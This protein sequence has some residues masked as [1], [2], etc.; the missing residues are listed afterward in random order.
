MFS[1]LA[2]LGLLMLVA[3]ATM[4]QGGGSTPHVTIGGSV[5]GGGNLANVG[6][7]STVLVD[8][9]GTVIGEDVYGGGAL[10]N[11]GTTS[12]DSTTVTILN[13][14]ING[15][16]YGGGLGDSIQNCY[17]GSINKA[18]LVYGKVYVNIGNNSGGPTINGSV[19]GC[20]NINGTPLDSVFVNIYK[21][22]H[23][24]SNSY[25][26]GIT[27]MAG[28]QASFN[29]SN[30]DDCFAIEAVYGGGNKASYK[31]S[32]ADRATT[33][34]VYGCT[35]NTIKVIYGGGNA[36][37]VGTSSKHANTRL[38]IEGGRFDQ[39]FGGGNGYSASG[40]H[41]PNNC[42]DPDYNPG[43]NITGTASTDIQGGLYRQIFGGSN[44]FGDVDVVALSIDKICDNL[45]ISEAFGGANEAELQANVETNLGCGDYEIGSFYGGSNKANIV[46]DVTLNVYGG[47]YTNVFG[48]SKGVAAAT[49]LTAVPANIDGNVTLNLFGGTMVNAFGGSDKNGNIT[50]GITVN[51]LD[52]E[53]TNCGLDVTNI[54]GA[55]NETAYSPTDPTITSPVVNVMH[56]AQ[57]AGVK[58]NVF[59]GGNLA[60]VTANPTVNIGYVSSMSSYITA[61]AA[62]L[63]TNYSV[64]ANSRA[65]VT[66]KVFGGGNEAGVTNTVVNINS[67][68]VK[69]G[70]YGGCNTSGTVGGNI[71][72]NL[73]NGQVGTDATNR[74]DVF[75]G[76]YGSNTY[77]SGDIVVNLNSTTIYGDLYGGSA[78]G[79]V[80]N[81]TA[82]PANT[83]TLTINGSALHG[84]IYGGGKGDVTNLG[85]GHNNVTAVNNGN[86]IVNYNTANTALT[87]LYGGANVNGNVKGDITVNV[88]ANVGATGTG[89]SVDVFGG[90]LGA[91]TDT[92]GNVTVNIGTETMAAA[93]IPVIYGDIYGGSALG[94]VNN[95]A[96]DITKVDFLNGTLHGNIYGG[97]L[98]DANN[99]AKVNGEVIVNI[100]S[101]NQDGSDCH[102]NLTDNVSIYGCNNTNGS[103][104]A[105]V[106]VN[107]YKTGFT[108]GDYDSQS[109]TLY[110]IDQ[111]FGGGKNADYLPENGATNSDKVAKVYVHDCANSIR[112]V[113]SGGDAADATGVAATID[114]GR[115]DFIFGGGN[116]EVSEA[117]IFL[118]GTNLI[119]HA[120]IINHLFGGSN[121]SGTI[122]GSMNTHIDGDN[123]NAACAESI[124]EFFGGG[125]LAPITGDIT[126]TLDCGIGNITNVYGG[127]NMASIT[128]DVTLT[129]KGGNYTNAF[130]GSKGV[131]GSGSS[132]GTTANIDGNVTLNLHGG[133]IVNAFGGSDQKG[134]ITGS[135]TVNVLDFE[136]T[137]CPLVVTNIY[138]GGNVTPYTP[139]SA[140]NSPMVNVMH[141][142][143]TAG[144]QGDV[145]GG[146]LGATAIVT[147]NPIVK[148]GYDATTMSGLL[149]TGYTQPATGFPR[150]VVTGDVYG[151]GSLAAVTGNTS[152]LIQTAGTEVKSNVFGGG[153]QA[154]V[155]GTSTVQV[156]NGTVGTGVYGGCNT[157]GTVGGAINVYIDGGT[158]GSSTTRADGVFGGG[159]GQS[160]NTGDNITVTIGNADA[161]T[162][163]IYGDIYGGSAKGNVNSSTAS[164][165]NTTKVWL[166]KGTI[167]GDI[168]G[169]GYGLDNVEALVYGNVQVVVDG[170]TVNSYTSGTNTLGGRIFG[171]N[172]AKGTPKGTVEVTI[173]ATNASSGSGSTKV[174]ALQGVYGGGNLAGYDPTTTSADYPI[175]TVNGCTSS[176]KDVYGGGNAAPVP[177]TKVIINGGDIKRMFA[178][179]NGESGTPAHVGYKNIDANPSGTGY[180]TGQ[181]QAE[182]KGGTIEQVFG[183]SNAN[184][185]IRV[186]SLLNVD[187]STASGACAMKIGEVYGGGNMANGNAGIINIGCTGDLVALG[188][189]EHY[190]VDQEGIRYVYGGANQAN[191]SNDILLNINSGIV[192][193]VFGGN[194]QS[195][196]I[197][198][199]ITV[200]IDSTGTCGWYVGNVYG[201][202]NQAT[203]GTANS[204]YPQ[205]N[206][207]NG[208]VSGDVFGGGLGSTGTAGQV[209]GNP[210][211]VVN[212]AK[213]RVNGGVYGGGSL[214]PTAGNPVVTLTNGALTN[215]YGGG[216]AANVNGAPTVNINGGTV[217][218]GVYGGCDSQGNVSGNI[219]VNVKSGV[220]G[221]QA[222][223]NN[224][225]LANVFGG[226]FG[227]STT[228][229]GNVEVNIDSLANI[230]APVIYGDVYG[231]SAFGSVNNEATD[232]TSV[233]I[234]SGSITG[235]VYGGGLGEAGNNVKGTVNGV[236]TVNVGTGTAN[237]TTGFAI[238]TEGFAIIGGS[239]YGG[240]NTGGS[241]QDDVYVNI[242]KA[243]STIA[244]VFGGSNAADY[245]PENGSTTTS[246]KARV[247]IYGCDNTIYRVFGGGN[248]AAS[249]SVETFIEGGTFNQVFGGGNG[250]L[251]PSYGADIHGTVDLGIHGGNV[252]QFFGGS[253]QNGTISGAINVVVDNTS[254]CGSLVIDEFFCGGNFVDITGNLETDILCSE[255]MV[256][257]DLYGGC[258]QA[259][260]SGNVVL[261]VYGG[262][263]TNVY[264]GSK[265]LKAD[266][267]AVPPVSA[268]PAN[269]E[270]GITLNLFGGTMENVYGGSNENGNIN[271]RIVV[272][273]L[274]IMDTQCPLNITNIYGG[275]NLTD[276]TP[277]NSAIISPVINIVHIKNG[278]RGN[279]YGGSKGAVGVAT[280]TLL[281]ANPQV[282]VGYDASM[283][284]Y[285]PSTGSNAYSVPS[286]P[287]AIISGD[288]FG[289]GDAATVEGNTIIY[290]RNRS[291]VFG[292]IYGGGNMGEVEGDTKVIVNGEN[293]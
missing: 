243:G 171:C 227:P 173:N 53:A 245:A 258:N 264:G 12:A 274:D 224:N 158:I 210:Q 74:A 155:S 58:G 213:A 119:V 253:N 113:F 250:E 166:K 23:T 31:P 280:P 22:A 37:D 266:P 25:P 196:S 260:I 150:A 4:A 257:H 145:F 237:T 244:N 277:T 28:L 169:G 212:G 156:A 154:G 290:L 90:G 164:P 95:A 117:N 82:N 49:G 139:T 241:P 291:K 16:V 65:Y 69:A 79:S 78:F 121:T 60:A 153:S 208:L 120:G 163:Q 123:M 48:G 177:N 107:I 10:A 91:A 186:S 140:T 157:S 109:G 214:A 222:N 206:I 89:N 232:K 209:T 175:V 183:G 26:T 203:Y 20:N 174:Y 13:G 86:V 2:L 62:Y 99:A 179:G 292:N 7:N 149:P 102:I 44:Q 267:S 57:A 131:A 219:T 249:P 133:T 205:V 141:V 165:L 268:H 77:T 178:G 172:N 289:G 61:I 218:T 195:G 100:S 269:I 32:V 80:N 189:G 146:G 201:G 66:G 29:A 124:T 190:G 122:A 73:I 15:N 182:I 40:N 159:F 251:G 88:L 94:N 256:V 1:R 112:R 116:G 63:P 76:G 30:Y 235:D 197:S 231:G 252:G 8:Q 39:I 56:I 204:N 50:G 262:I 36:A 167:T 54:Y 185:A 34:H 144:V 98:G 83:T 42:N 130:G 217:S 125:N 242:W 194:N 128:G 81:A 286:S 129:I 33:V 17:G 87:G 199:N 152:V 142:K 278:I 43:A 211:V 238:T 255:G 188:S 284:T 233:N 285:I 104:Q 246:K 281:R 38:I 193:N 11:V 59:G 134:N 9:N 184:G 234:Y 64:P 180:G 202:G 259:N 293:Q 263:Y 108:T 192:E 51:V 239:V 18:A 265:G 96:T 137:E 67:G 114:G 103:P 6:G 282:N 101:A 45:L 279:V 161:T 5:F 136:D 70:V 93:D 287:R 225:I 21:T 168:Y 221:T 288:V 126:T 19:F 215:V 72:V 176:I 46:G 143:Q 276:Y 198:G 261:N 35:E 14:V 248:A 138:G 55:S 24:T 118:G 240:N 283:N 84:T 47:T 52:L 170:G 187:K 75:G 135:I 127:S 41:D 254:N 207:S 151:G 115:F 148:I 85:N 271:G 132:T 275:S 111:V 106:T 200:N 229:S 160:T 27:T 226:G 223:F 97:G 105:D 71:A 247:H 3:S 230:L 270:G 272:N 147:A 92:E 162:P 68:I 228:T 181:A 191:I 216:K 273:V 220:I 110:A 236:V